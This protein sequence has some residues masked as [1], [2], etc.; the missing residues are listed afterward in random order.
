MNSE[1]ASRLHN[2]ARAASQIASPSSELGRRARALLREQTQLSVEGIEFALSEC[3]ETRTSRSA[4]SQLVRQAPAA[5]QVHV[6]L[7]AQVF[8]AAYR[9]IALALAQSQRVFVRSSR[10]ESTMA[11]LL[12]EASGGAFQLTDTLAPAA[13][14]HYWAYG[15][16]ETLDTIKEGLP[17][18]VRF[19]GHGAGLGVAVIRQPRKTT[20]PLLTH[21]ADALA[22]DVL[23]FDQ[24]GCLSPRLVLVEGDEDF[25]TAMAQRI[26]ES[27]AQWQTVVPRGTLSDEETA[28]AFKYTTTMTYLGT[29]FEAGTGL[30]AVD[31]TPE[32]LV[33]PP[34]GRFLHVTRTTEPLAR[35]KELGSKLTTVAFF[36]GEHLEGQCQEELGPRRYVNLGQMQRPPLDGPV[37]RRTGWAFEVL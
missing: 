34:V 11:S 10:R 4:L 5:P 12:C 3:L 14:D 17:S 37:D 19:H 21:A 22:Q 30:V 16:D 25:S 24:R 9:A 13:G 8:V 18:G 35:L 1:R 33:I 26:A 23:A 27:L 31:P 6:L 15:S 29:A 36:H 7:S 32:R 28:D 20:G 2:L